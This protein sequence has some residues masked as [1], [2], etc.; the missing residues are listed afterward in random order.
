MKPCNAGDLVL[1]D[2]LVIH[3][4]ERNLS[5]KSRF[6]FT[7]HLIDGEVRYDEKN[8]LQPSAALPFSPIAMPA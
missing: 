7:F 6:I 2:G 4:S 5:D 1:I 8:W 3:R